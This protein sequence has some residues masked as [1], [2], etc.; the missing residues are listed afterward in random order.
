MK[1]TKIA[2]ICFMCA[3]V[4]SSCK[5][6]TKIGPGDAKV[7]FTFESDNSEPATGSV[8]MEVSE[9][10]SFQSIPIRYEGT[11]GGYPIVVKVKV[12]TSS[13][14]KINEVINVTSTT[15]KI[16][17]KNN[18]YI[19]FYPVPRP[20]VSEDCEVKFTIEEVTGANIGTTKECI[21]NIKS[22]DAVRYGQYTFEPAVGNPEIWQFN[23]REG[24]GGLY[25]LENMFGLTSSPKLIGEYDPNTNELVFNGRIFGKG[26][27]VWFY[28]DLGAVGENATLL[29]SGQSF[30]EPIRFQINEDWELI[31]ADNSSVKYGVFNPVTG[32]QINIYGEWNGG[33]TVE[34]VGSLPGDEWPFE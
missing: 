32:E 17:E 4:L 27:T 8:T 3:S 29:L 28:V 7:Y 13:D 16:T 11:P 34:L 14:V 1:Y 9:N 6:E 33:A 10:A 18:S 22:V 25:I 19:Q 12:E 30:I 31:S 24:P 2:L 20:D 15:I 26:E 23:L 5:T 21:V